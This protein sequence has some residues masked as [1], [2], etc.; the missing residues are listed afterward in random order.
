MA[1][2]A[3]TVTIQGKKAWRTGPGSFGILRGTVNVTNYNT[4]LAEIT[5][6]SKKFRD[7]P[8]VILNSISSLGHCGEWVAA[9]KSIKCWFPTQQTGGAGNRAGIEAATDTNIGVF[10]FIAIGLV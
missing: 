2:Y 9:S 3:A 8:T 1:A 5:G 10:S 4:T 7:T 6:I